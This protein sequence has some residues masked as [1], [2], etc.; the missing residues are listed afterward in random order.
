MQDVA[1]KVGL[2]KKTIQRYENGE[3]KIDMKRIS[4]IANAL[5][6]TVKDLTEGATSYLGLDVSDLNS[7]SLPVVGKVSCGNGGL[8]YVE[9]S[10]YESTPKQWLDGEEYFYLRAKGDSMTGARIFEGDLLLIRK[11]PDVENGEIA[12]VQIND[13]AVLKRVFKSSGTIV[14]QSENIN[15]EPII[16]QEGT[17]LI[18][19][20]LKKIMIDV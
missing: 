7:V 16:C 5:D 11:Q 1:D 17:V 18:L 4:D 13:E 8:T 19:G 9:I 3:I 6:V 10:G 12:A 20:K 2:T 15:Y 14:L